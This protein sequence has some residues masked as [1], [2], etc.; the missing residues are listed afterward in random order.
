M[1]HRLSS[2]VEATLSSFHWTCCNMCRDWYQSWTL[3]SHHAQFFRHV[4]LQPCYLSPIAFADPLR[5]CS[6][7]RANLDS[8]LI[9][10]F[11]QHLRYSTFGLYPEQYT[12][13]YRV[14]RASPKSLSPI[15]EIEHLLGSHV[16][17]CRKSLLCQLG[18]LYAFYEHK[19]HFD[20]IMT[21]G[22][23]VL[24][25][26][27]MRFSTRIFARSFCSF[28]GP[29]R[30]NTLVILASVPIPI[31]GTGLSRQVLSCIECE[32]YW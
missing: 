20:V 14:R 13:G 24:A 26:Q 5:L 29:L 18:L 32:I 9:C 25:V 16:P 30:D 11:V 23:S 12:Y 19:T 8:V 2:H 1:G 3:L 4:H 10:G 31:I 28:I 17:P 21:T 6:I 22:D 7:Q 15:F 27:V